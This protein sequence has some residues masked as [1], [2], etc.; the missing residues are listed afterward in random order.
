MAPVYTSHLLAAAEIRDRMAAP[1]VGVSGTAHSSLPV[2]AKAV[3]AICLGISYAIF[4][5]VAYAFATKCRL[6]ALPEWYHRASVRGLGGKVLVA[7]WF[8]AVFLLWPIVFSAYVAS[9]CGFPSY[10]GLLGARRNRAES[11]EAGPGGRREPAGERRNSVGLERW[12]DV[13][14]DEERPTEPEPEPERKPVPARGVFI[15]PFDETR[16]GRTAHSRPRGAEASPSR[17]PKDTGARGYGAGIEEHTIAWYV[18][19]PLPEEMVRD[20]AARTSSSATSSSPSSSSSSR[21]RSRSPYD[22]D[23]GDDSTTTAH[24]PTSLPFV[25]EEEPFGKPRPRLQTIPESEREGPGGWEE[26]RLR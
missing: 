23:G 24:L 19:L 16:R 9:R 14:L 21:G 8:P 18:K 22:R 13:P 20:A 10:K 15:N 6:F 12:F 3:V 26:A 5:V 17:S 11:S 7:L 2:D 4:G 1:T 25:G